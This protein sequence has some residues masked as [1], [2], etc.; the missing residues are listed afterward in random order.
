MQVIDGGTSSLLKEGD[1]V[2][3]REVGMGSWTSHRICSDTQLIKLKYPLAPEIGAVCSINPGTAFRMLKDF[4]TLGRG[5]VFI[6]NGGTSAVAIYATQLAKLWGVTS[7]SIIRD[8]GNATD[9]GIVKDTLRNEFGATF[10]ITEQEVKSALSDILAQTGPAKLALNCVGGKGVLPLLKGLGKSGIVVTYGGMNRLPMQ[11]PVSSLIF[12]DVHIRGFWISGWIEQRRDTRL[13]Q[14]MLD[15]LTEA[16]RNASLKPS[17]YEKFDLA[18][19][20]R[21]A[22]SKSL[23]NDQAPQGLNKKNIFVM[24]DS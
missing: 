9:T 4:A 2:I 6:Q 3:H 1:R 10:V 11:V 21:E 23:F 18:T 17:P 13:R 22:L 14:E 5:D 12:S 24:G 15:E 19:E 20:W 16:F 8:R 7:I